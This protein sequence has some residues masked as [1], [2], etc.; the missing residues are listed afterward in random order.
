MN[1]L[2]VIGNLDIG[3]AQEVVRTLADYLHNSGQFPVVCTFKDG[4]LRQEIER[5][6]I[7][8]EVLPKRRHSILAFPQFLAEMAAT[9]KALAGLV[10]KYQID[11][12]QTHLLRSLDFLALTLRFEAGRPLIFW[13]VHNYNFALRADDLP[14]MKWL[15]APKIAAHSLL[16]RLSSAWV[17]G[18]IAVSPQV[19]ASILKNI[20]PVGS[21][22]TTICNGVDV[23]RYSRPVD[24]AA[25]RS[26]LG[27]SE[28]DCLMI[29]VGTL[30]DQKGHRVLIEAA[31]EVVSRFPN[32]RI[33]LAGDGPLKE[34]L[35]AQ[36]RAADLESH[37][38]FL[39][40]RSDVPELLGA[41]DIFVLPSLWEGLPMALIEGMASALPIVATSVSGTQ[42]VMVSG[43]TGLLV[44]PGSPESLSEA[45]ISL[46]SDPLRARQMGLAARRRVETTFSA[47]KQAEE[48]IA[49]FKSV[50]R[51]IRNAWREPV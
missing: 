44:P 11:V 41:S 3:G 13:T 19:E 39:G 51:G 15:L 22:I 21:K 26:S 5:L 38:R 33:L 24:R 25:M 8:V 4:P 10:R 1:I 47:R 7:P 48:H 18:F 14:N 43:E 34:E 23:A 32:L 17:D 36:V 45:I 49:L 35:Q 30:K 6:G 31:P 42:Q 9:R 46:L 12:V 20:G 16:Y 27:L 28:G 37:V 29:V 50:G 40:S 2:E